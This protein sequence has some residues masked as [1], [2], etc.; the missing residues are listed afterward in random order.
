[1]SERGAI[2]LDVRDLSKTYT[3][4]R[5][6]VPAL[7]SVSLTAL[8][9]EFV[10][11][12]GPSGCGKSTMLKMI[13]GVVPP[14]S[15]TILF[16]AREAKG[17]RLDVGMVFQTPALPPWRTVIENVLLPIQA[18]GLRK[19]AYLDRARALLNLVGLAG[20]ENSYPNELS[21]G[22]QQRVSLCRALIHEPQLLLMDEPFG[23]LDAITREILQAELRRI[24]NETKKT[25]LFVTHSIDEAVFLG[26]R[27][28]LMSSR[29][30]RI[31]DEMPVA[32]ENRGPGTDIR[33]LEEFR[34]YA[35]RLRK[36]LGLSPGVEGFDHSA[37]RK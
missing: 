15:G 6:S 5:G 8:A 12:V 25:V 13:L 23:A 19:H 7:D 36:G 24:W 20:F 22:M 1:M 30:G 9:G 10:T 32:F 31:V 27:V 34:N 18:L 29:P 2:R 17:A 35:H 16:N 33:A 26:T 14:D 21:G 4:R 11:I 28:L 37:E 3:T